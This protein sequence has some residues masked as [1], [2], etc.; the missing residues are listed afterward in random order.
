MSRN[1]TKKSSYR[2]SDLKS[3][4]HIHQNIDVEQLELHKY[5]TH[6]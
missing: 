6:C 5:I 3:Q 2:R 4:I 1:I